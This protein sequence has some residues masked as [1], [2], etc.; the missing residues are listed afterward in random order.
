MTTDKDKSSPAEPARRRRSPA[1][2]YISWSTLFAAV[3][4][5]V[6]GFA[7]AQTQIAVYA[8]S[9]ATL[10]GIPGEHTTEGQK[11][12]QEPIV[13]PT[14]YY[15]YVE[16][17]PRS[18]VSAKWV[19]LQG[20]YYAGTLKKVSTPVQV[21]SDSAVPTN[22]KETLVAKTSNDVYSIVLGD[23]KV[24]QPS[25]DAERE[26][27]ANNSVVVS[28]IVDKSTSYAMSRSIKVLRP[29]AAM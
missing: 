22:K 21:E 2:L 24:Q 23:K 7:M 15:L 20:N 27:V 1:G 6:V 16:V 4:A 8:Y 10:P 3:L 9:R 29:A 19:W 26:L 28:L 13:F 12:T 18:H 14:K 11:S 17:P 5:A 25:N